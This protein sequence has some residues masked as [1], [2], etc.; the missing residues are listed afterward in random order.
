MIKKRISVP[1]IIFLFFTCSAIFG[2]KGID[3]AFLEQVLTENVSKA[4]NYYIYDTI[5]IYEEDSI[6]YFINCDLSHIG[7]KEIYIIKNEIPQN[8]DVYR[9]HVLFIYKVTIKRKNIEVVFFNSRADTTTKVLTAG[10]ML[11]YRKKQGKYKL[12]KTIVS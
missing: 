6:K 11:T 12:I 5:Y 10:L 2:Q 8:Y 4:F 1:I 9:N 7:T 3:C